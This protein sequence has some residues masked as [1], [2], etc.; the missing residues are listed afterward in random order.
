MK[1][2]TLPD[3]YSPHPARRNPHYAY[4]RAHAA[5]WA[6]RLGMLGEPG[7]DGK[8]IWDAEKL[9]RMDYALLCAYTH[10]DC[11]AETLALLTEW[12]IWVF[13][14]DDWFLSQYKATRN[15]AEATRYLR[16]LE[17]FMGEPGCA[18]PQPETPSEAGLADCWARTIPVMSSGWRRRMRT[19]T[20]NL[21]VESLWELDNI[22][23]DRVANPIEYIEMRRRVG[24][25]PWSANLVEFACGAEVPER[26]A[27]E[28]PLRVLCETFSDAVHLRNDLFSYEREVRVEGE[29]A[30]MVL[31]LERFLRLPTQ[32]AAELTNDMLTS[33]LKQFEDTALVDVPQ[34]FVE[35]AATPAEQSAVARYAVGLQDWQAGGHEW[36]QR[37][38]RYMNSGVDRGPT[39]LGTASIRLAPGLRVQLKQHVP[40]PRTS[41]PLPVRGLL[42]P[43]VIAVNPHLE[44]TRADLPGWAASVG[45]FDPVVG[46]TA[47]SLDA[48]DFAALMAM[49]DP[50]AEADELV[51]RSRW[52]AWGTYANDLAARVFRADPISG[53]D[54]LRRLPLQLTEAAPPPRTPLELGLARLWHDSGPG[55]DDA[56]RDRLRAALIDLFEEWEYVLENEIRQRMPDPVDYLELRRLTSG[57][58][59]FR[60]MDVP[61]SLEM[62]SEP[63]ILEL[64]DSSV[65]RQ[66]ENSAHDYAALV[67]DLYSYQREIEYEGELHNLVYLT[68]SFLGCSRETAADIVVDL[69]NERARQFEFIVREQIPGFLAD[70]E[71]PGRARA[72]VTAHI[73]RLRNHM[74]GNAYWHSHTGRYAER[75]PARR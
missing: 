32:S 58:P 21:M 56:G 28:R 4:A 50:D 51:L 37:S 59:L 27:A 71:L 12:Y 31:V 45:L 17:Q 24:G 20:H 2:F 75:T 60:A 63:R 62:V 8:P 15:R 73:D 19:S 53:R 74:A 11:D 7:V 16:R 42:T 69:A 64:A 22:A 68:Q 26:F 55:L 40:P 47:E 46:W 9:D 41:G 3:F 23:R 70:H 67:N 10:P 13:Y 72:E 35:R 52:C 5:A 66:L 48:A 61:Q 38:S 65:I 30:N 34:L 33:R 54:Q 44:T 14:F 25:A 6:D 36:H 29:N 39:G 18:A 49:V 43:P 1:P 57:G